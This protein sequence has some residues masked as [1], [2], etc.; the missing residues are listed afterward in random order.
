MSTKKKPDSK[1]APR[2]LAGGAYSHKGGVLKQ[3]EPS[4]APPVGKSVE[5]AQAERAAPAKTDA[6]A[7]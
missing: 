4:T 5:R 6:A 2:P 3:D 1:P 7:G